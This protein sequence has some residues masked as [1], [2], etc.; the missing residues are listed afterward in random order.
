MARKELSRVLI[1]SLPHPAMLVRNDQ[2][3]L[4]ANRM[5]KEAGAREGTRCWQSFG[6]S[7]F[8][9]GDHRGDVNEHAGK[10]PPGG[11][12][13]TFCLRREA[14]A[15]KALKCVPEVSA[16][17]KFWDTYWVPVTDSLFL[18]YAVDVTQRRVMQAAT[19]ESE[20]KYRLLFQQAADSIAILDADTGHIVEFNDRAHENLGYTREEFA[21][22]TIADFEAV[23]SDREIRA[24]LEK[25]RTAGADNF[26]TRHLT[27]TGK[28]RDIA[29]SARAIEI[30]GKTFVQ[31]VWRDITVQK[32]A[33]QDLEKRIAGRTADLLAANAKLQQE[34]RKRI[35]AEKVLREKETLLAVEARNLKDANNAL[36][37]MLRQ[38]E[39]DKKELEE[40]VHSNIKQRINPILE[41]LRKA[42]PG[43]HQ[44]HLVLRLE[45]L[46]NDIVFPFARK[47]SSPL[48][49]LTPSEV[50][51]ACLVRE[52]RRSKEIA[53]ELNL[54]QNT[55]ACHRSKIRR[56]LG[57]SGKRINLRS[58]L[59]SLEKW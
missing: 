43:A 49:G 33:K 54:S 9:S 58:Y 38:H 14:M 29:V 22:L 30:G 6:L 4:F 35:A 56:K 8:L 31:S 59:Q 2:V 42:S 21:K 52:G 5:A 7:E 12:G 39:V 48:I 25:I 10:L 40:S 20:H 17:G 51:V 13:C 37:L 26:E 3:I 28:V 1:D 45:M 15:E 16:F 32:N 24:R 19:Q 46:L 57:L 27:K 50:Q 11:T 44:Q 47:I 18:H 34:I 41:R 36:K 55:V 23:E 53:A